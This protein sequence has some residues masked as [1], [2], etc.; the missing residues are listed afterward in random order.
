M[1]AI[2]VC[3]KCGKAMDEEKQFYK[4]RDGSRMDLCKKCLTMHVDNFNPDTFTWILK[5][6]DFPYV[7][8]EWNIIRNKEFAKNPNLDGTSVLGK[9]LSK[10]RIKQWSDKG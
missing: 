8:A 9:Y 10:M 7:P 4:R 2:K 1:G 5:E 6:M 3:L